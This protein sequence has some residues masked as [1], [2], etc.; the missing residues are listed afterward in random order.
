[1]ETGA[2][3]EPEASPT[4]VVLQHPSGSKVGHLGAALAPRN[5]VQG[6][7]PDCCR[8]PAPQVYLVGTAHVSAQ[9]AQEAA[10]TIQ[11]VGPVI[12][13][14]ELD[15]ERF[16]KLSKAAEEYGPFGLRKL[17]EKGTLQVRAVLLCCC[18]LAVGGRG[19][20]CSSLT[21]TA[22]VA[23]PGTGRALPPHHHRPH[24]PHLPRTSW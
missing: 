15:E 24:P 1:M 2:A 3:A 6:A 18:F 8:R 12:V 17:Q 23:P 4:L 13:V 20:C 14:L 19:S 9:A 7:R 21:L 5:P 16:E 10:D 11:R 22:H